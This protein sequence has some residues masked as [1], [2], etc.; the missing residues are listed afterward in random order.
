LDLVGGVGVE[1]EAL[2]VEGGLGD[3]GIASNPNPEYRD[4]INK[5]YNM[6]QHLS[7]STRSELMT[8][9]NAF[10]NKKAIKEFL[11]SPITKRSEIKRKSG[12]ATCQVELS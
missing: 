10:W 2:G 7:V 3:L 9:A 4:V 8:N 1:G 6:P 12:I 11:E 5:C